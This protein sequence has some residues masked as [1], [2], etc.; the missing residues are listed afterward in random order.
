[1]AMAAPATNPSRLLVFGGGLLLAGFAAGF[2]AGQESMRQTG[3]ATRAAAQPIDEHAGHDHGPAGAGAE[4]ASVGPASVPARTGHTF[5]GQLNVPPHSEKGHALAQTLLVGAT[6]PCG[7]CQGMQLLECGCD[8][9][10][11]VEGLAA[12][13]LERGKPDAE[14]LAQLSE[15]FGLKGAR[16]AVQTPASGLDGLA[17]AFKTLPGIQG[18]ANVPSSA[19]RTGP[20]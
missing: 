13:L 14:V 19:R 2:F 12:H 7:G 3:V 5:T 16:A 10:R 20:E 8:T 4:P 11:E 18:P 17:D 15:H 9:A 1:M 6:C